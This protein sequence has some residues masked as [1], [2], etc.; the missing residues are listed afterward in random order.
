[1]KQT[2]DALEM[3][4][5]AIEQTNN[6]FK[7]MEGMAVTSEILLELDKVGRNAQTMHLVLGDMIDVLDQQAQRRVFAARSVSPLWRDKLCQFLS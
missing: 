7:E 4:K 5:E 3:A 2:N 6:D 1:L